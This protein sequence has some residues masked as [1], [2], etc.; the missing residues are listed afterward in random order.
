[1]ATFFR[2]PGGRLKRFRRRHTYH[3]CGKRRRGR[4][5][6]GYGAC[7]GWEPSLNRRC[8]REAKA[9]LRRAWADPD[10]EYDA[11]PCRYGW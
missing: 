11:R 8:R 3:P 6:V 7:H 1:M 2:L 10:S 5:A 9:E 4:P